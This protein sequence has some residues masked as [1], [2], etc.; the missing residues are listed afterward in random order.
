MKKIVFFS[1]LIIVISISL[2]LFYNPHIYRKI[3]FK[4]E[5]PKIGLLPF[6]DFS[7][8]DIEVVKTELAKRYGFDIAILP[9][10]KLPAMAYTTIKKPRYRADSLLNWLETVLP[11]SLDALIGLTN[12]DISFTKYQEDSKTIKDPEWM[13]KDFGIFGLGRVGGTVAVVSS[14][15][16]RANVSKEKFH[17]RL[18]RITSHELGH[19]LGLRHCPTKEC[20]MNDANESI[21]TIDQSTG[22]LCED[23]KSKIN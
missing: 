23:C 3:Q 1:S 2:F 13:Y 19:V 8:K 6:E 21:K 20:L 18:A 12:R 16:L 4:N 15:R 5:P 22:E 9:Q 14:N 17:L 11:D 10:F 7:E